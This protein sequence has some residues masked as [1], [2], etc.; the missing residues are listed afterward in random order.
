MQLFLL[1][2]REI[3][4]FELLEKIDV[5]FL[6]ARFELF[7]Q[8]V[9]HLD[10]ERVCFCVCIIL[11]TQENADVEFHRRRQSLVL[12]LQALE[13]VEEVFLLEVLVLKELESPDSALDLLI[14]H[15]QTAIRLKILFLL[16]EG[17]RV[18]HHQA[19]VEHSEIMGE[20]LSPQTVDFLP[21]NLF[22]LILV[23]DVLLDC[24]H[25]L[26]CFILLACGYVTLQF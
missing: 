25:V 1:L 8:S 23:C 21:K 16:D 6:A 24:V 2:I 22:E 4:L 15:Q 26:K 17:F 5:E 7:F 18:V 19:A 9:P 13:L 10:F 12:L 3:K 20:L 14:L 11:L